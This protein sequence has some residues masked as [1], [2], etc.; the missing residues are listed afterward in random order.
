[1][2]EDGGSGGSVAGI[3]TGFA[4][5]ALDELCTCILESVVEFDFLCHAH[6]VFGDAGSTEFLVDDNIAS[7]GTESDFDGI[8]ERVGT[9]AKT[10]AGVSIVDD[11]FCHGVFYDF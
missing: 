3:V 6:T 1:M 10:F 2:G 8:G 5:Y 9:F 11:F 4:C 7:L